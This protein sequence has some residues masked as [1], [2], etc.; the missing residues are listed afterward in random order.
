MNNTVIIL[1]LHQNSTEMDGK[2]MK[3]FLAIPLFNVILLFILSIKKTT[4]NKE[5]SEC[6]DIHTRFGLL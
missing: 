4:K 5:N 1:Q 3:H 6:H 2:K